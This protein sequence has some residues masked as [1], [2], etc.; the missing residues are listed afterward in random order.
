[1]CQFQIVISILFQHLLFECYL[2]CTQSI[3][4]SQIDWIYHSCSNSGVTRGGRGG[5]VAHPW[6]VS[7]KFLKK[8]GNK[9]KREG[10]EEKKRKEKE[11]QGKKGEMENKRSEIVKGEEENKL[12][13]EGGNGKY[14][15]WKWAEDLF[16][17]FFFFFF[18]LLVTIWNHWNLFGVYQNGIFLPGKKQFK[19][20]NIAPSEKYSSYA[21][22]YRHLLWGKIFYTFFDCLPGYAPVQ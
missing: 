3:C 13:M 1:M 20:G 21:T 19:P 10:R 4:T 9:E 5:R 22:V 17:F 15:V 7:G 8:G 12:K 6:K 14:K 16:F 18:F 2:S 11:R